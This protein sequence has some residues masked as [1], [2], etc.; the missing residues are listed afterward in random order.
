VGT[1][2]RLET[3]HKIG[4]P[5]QH[6]DN[7]NAQAKLEYE[8]TVLGLPTSEDAEGRLYEPSK[9]F[10]KRSKRYERS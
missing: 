7:N 3:Q 8:Q 6:N 10:F 4:L 2:A 1:T 5:L 9:L